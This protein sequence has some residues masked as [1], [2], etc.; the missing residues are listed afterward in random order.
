[1]V[2]VDFRYVVAQWQSVGVFDII[3]PV[4]LIFTLVFAILQKTKLLGSI[5][6]IDA[7]VALVM[8]GFSIANPGVTAFF[9]PIFSNFALGIIILMSAML[10]IGLVFGERKAKGIY[11]IG[12]IAAI[13]IF[14]WILSR[15]FSYYG[16]YPYPGWF[17]DNLVWIIPVVLAAIAVV[18]IM[19]G[20]RTGEK[21]AGWKAFRESFLEKLPD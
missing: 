10:L 19:S 5:K 15:V 11:W 1:M 17:S 18:V 13:A 4:L 2:F 6:G 3:L 14:I 20:E 8:A 21:K 16:Y 12:S 7:I 9:I